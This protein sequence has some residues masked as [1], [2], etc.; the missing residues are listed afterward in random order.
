MNIRKATL[1]IRNQGCQKN[2]RENWNAV[3]ALDKYVT[4]AVAYWSRMLLQLV[5]QADSLL[6]LGVTLMCHS[7]ALAQLVHA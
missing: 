7:I 5:L 1:Q 3:P 4:S 6:Q 2:A